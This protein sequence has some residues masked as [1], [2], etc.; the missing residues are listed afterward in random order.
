LLAILTHKLAYEISN[1]LKYPH[2]YRD[3]DSEGADFESISN[4]SFSDIELSES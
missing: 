3:N 2:A 4:S 1:F